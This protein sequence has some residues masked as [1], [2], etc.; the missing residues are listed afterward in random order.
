MTKF[1][2]ILLLTL[3]IISCSSVKEIQDESVSVPRV[4]KQK[5]FTE[6]KPTF[7]LPEEKSIASFESDD[8]LEFEIVRCYGNPETRELMIDYR[9]KNWGPSKQFF[10]SAE[11]NLASINGKNHNLNCVELNGIEECKN[12]YLN[13]KITAKTD[14][15]WKGSC[16]FRNVQEYNSDLIDK[17]VLQYK[18]KQLNGPK[19]FAE[20]KNVPIVWSPNYEITQA[21]KIPKRLADDNNGLFMQL[22]HAVLNETTRELI[23]SYTMTNLDGKARKFYVNARDNE[24][25]Y[26]NNI[27]DISCAGIDGEMECGYFTVKESRLQPGESI[28]GKFTFK[29]IK[30]LDNSI[31]KLTLRYN[32]GVL[33][34]KPYYAVFSKI[35]LELEQ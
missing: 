3:A 15:V 33:W 31:N 24:M 14:L 5:K 10:V 18:H 9:V 20:F 4:V 2:S 28:G 16:T 32:E 34:T 21:D 11:G 1:I 22:E 13:S 17:L 7:K 12:Y 35:P 30:H 29:N 26:E 25:I 8:G 27:H 6:L 23:V 19:H